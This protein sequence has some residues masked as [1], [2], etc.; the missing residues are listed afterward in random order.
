M[1][2]PKGRRY[3]GRGKGTKNRRTV[4]REAAMAETAKQIESVIDGAFDGDGHA[5]LVAVYKDPWQPIELRLEAAK[6]A[7][8]YEKPKLAAVQ[9]SGEMHLTHEEALDELE[10]R[11]RDYQ[12]QER[13]RM[14]RAAQTPA[15]H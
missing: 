3:G 5:L 2:V 12:D 9:H 4:E 7:I 8:G 11:M 1:P 6:A 15:R 10:D 14:R 13:E